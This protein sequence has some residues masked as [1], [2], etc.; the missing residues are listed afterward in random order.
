MVIR[1]FVRIRED[2]RTIG[3]REGEHLVVNG[4]LGKA[5]EY[6]LMVRGV[7]CCYGLAVD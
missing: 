2:W 7:N 4:A 6:G 5:L 1:Q 3:S